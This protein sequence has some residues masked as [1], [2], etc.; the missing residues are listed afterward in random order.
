MSIYVKTCE[1][2]A[3]FI[4]KGGQKGALGF[5]RCIPVGIP[6]SN[7]DKGTRGFERCIPAGISFLK[8]E[9][10]RGAFERCAPV[11]IFRNVF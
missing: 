5:G 11:G 4:F 7:E 10:A 3:I 9:I 8:E 2:S 1:A 6:F